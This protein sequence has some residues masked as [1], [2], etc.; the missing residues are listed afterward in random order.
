MLTFNCRVGPDARGASCLEKLKHTKNVI[1]FSWFAKAA[2]KEVNVH[3]DLKKT[4]K[5]SQ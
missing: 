1:I 3:I 5:V 4:A 2:Y